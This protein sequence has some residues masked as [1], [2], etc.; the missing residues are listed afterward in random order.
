ML[1]VNDL[2]ADFGAQPDAIGNVHAALAL[3]AELSPRHAGRIAREVR[4]VH[5]GGARAP[6][7][8]FGGRAVFI[9]RS[10]ATTYPVEALAL[11]LVMGEAGTRLARVRPNA[12]AD[13]VAQVFRRQRLAAL[14]FAGRLPSPTA[15]E[16]WINDWLQPPVPASAWR[17]ADIAAYR[18]LLEFGAPPWLIRTIGWMKRRR[19]RNAF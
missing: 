14:D 3:I 6:T 4:H 5:I 15:W 1:H 12:R 9:S 11:L 2:S 10:A 16:K 17:V 13:T 18:Q 8:K 7:F 19:R